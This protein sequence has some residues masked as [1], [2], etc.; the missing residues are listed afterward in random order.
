M[1]NMIF[2][3]LNCKFIDFSTK[4]PE[5]LP[6]TFALMFNQWEAFFLIWKKLKKLLIFHFNTST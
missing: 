1:P 3:L 2:K 6:T 5:V 4:A